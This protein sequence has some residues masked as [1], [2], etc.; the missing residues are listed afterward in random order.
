[1]PKINKFENLEILNKSNEICCGILYLF[2][3]TN[4]GKRFSMK[5]QILRSSNST[6]NKI[7]KAFE[8]NGSR[9]IINFF[10]I[11]KKF[12]WRIKISII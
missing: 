5:D 3:I 12:L 4:L 7:T 2:E 11:I 1:M 6:M 8:R 9:E 10:K